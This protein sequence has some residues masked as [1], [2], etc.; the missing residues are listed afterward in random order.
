MN[1]FKIKF[2]NNKGVES[3][4]DIPAETISEALGYFGTI[5]P[6]GLEILAINDTKNKSQKEYVSESENIR[7]VELSRK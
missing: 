7:V 4:I 2:K 6:F 3:D 1:D 5:C